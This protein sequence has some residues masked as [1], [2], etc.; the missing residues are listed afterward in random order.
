[1]RHDYDI[2]VIGGGPAGISA[3]IWASDLNLTCALVERSRSLGGQLSYVFNPIR[4]YPGRDAKSG[5]EMRKHFVE[6]LTNADFDLYEGREVVYL[7]TSKQS[8]HLNDGTSVHGR[9]IIIATGVRRR[10]LNVPGE[11]CWRF[12]SDL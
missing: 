3:A 11:A 2:I 8:V 9:A 10:K 6:S 7:D 1:M 5:E 12:E 4:N